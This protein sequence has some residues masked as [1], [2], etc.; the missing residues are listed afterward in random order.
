[1]DKIYSNIDLPGDILTKIRGLNTEDAISN[2]IKI[3]ER[4]SYIL[5]PRR[6]DMF[7]QLTRDRTRAESLAISTCKSWKFDVIDNLEVLESKQ[8]IRR[9]SKIESIE[10]GSKDKTVSCALERNGDLIHRAFLRV[11]LP[12]PPK[13][14]TELPQWSSYNLIQDVTLEFSGVPY[15]THYFQGDKVIKYKHCGTLP[16]TEAI[17]MAK[18][19]LKHE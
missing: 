14:I 9:D 6:I 10:S 11:E 1:M 17:Q 19:K 16:E 5:L 7:E 8:T 3:L 2:L 4:D 12:E 15:E 13:S 18:L